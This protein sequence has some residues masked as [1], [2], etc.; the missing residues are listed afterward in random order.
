M[1]LLMKWSAERWEGIFKE[2]NGRG[3]ADNMALFFL[4]GKRDLIFLE[5]CVD[6]NKYVDTF[7]NVL[8]PWAFLTHGQSWTFQKHTTARH[9]DTQTPM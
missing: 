4:F 9:P 3:V 1:S 7:R 6:G 8:Q 2:V 5:G